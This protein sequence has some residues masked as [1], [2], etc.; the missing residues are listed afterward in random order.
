[1]AVRIDHFNIRV[2]DPSQSVAFYRLLELDIV[3]G[4]AIAPG[5]YL[6]YMGVPGDNR[7]TIELAVKED[8]G[9]DY[10]RTPGTGHLALAV[11]DLDALLKSLSQN[12]IEP[13]VAPFNPV[14]DRDIRICFVEDPDGVKVEL[15]EGDYPT[16]RDPV[17]VSAE[18]GPE[19][20]K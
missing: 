4:L 16:P 3:G 7:C 10:D 19:V 12:G 8:A 18:I 2:K 11:G 9:E 17:P 1:M 6:V 13:V 15:I 5:Y 20:V 14:P